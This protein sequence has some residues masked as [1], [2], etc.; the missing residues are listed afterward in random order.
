MDSSET[1]HPITHWLRNTNGF[2]FSLYVAFSAFCLY[3]CIFSLRKTFGV[4]TYDGIVVAGHSFKVWMVITQA[5]GYMLSKF[6]GIKIVSELG[7]HSRFKGILLMVSIAGLSWLGFALTPNPYN[8]IFLFFNG[9]PL[10][11]VWG[12]VFGYLEGRRSTEVLGASLSVSF[13]FSA[14]FAK[15]IGGFIMLHWGTSEFWMPFVSTCLFFPP[16]V[17]FLWMLNKIPPPTPEDEVLRTK[18]RPMSGPERIKLALTFAPGLILLI[19]AYTMLTA[20]RDFRDNFSAEI[21]KSLDYGDKPGIFT[22]TETIVTIVVL[23]V[24]GSLMVIKNNFKAMIINHFIVIIGMIT[25]GLSTMAFENKLIAAPTWMVLVGMGLYFGY[26]QFNSI[27]FDRIIATF[28]YVSTI[29]FLMYLADSFGYVGS[30]GVLLFKEFGNTELS[31][32]DFFMSS[33]YI[34][35]IA[36]SVLMS[37]SLVY[38]IWKFKGWKQG[39]VVIG[40]Q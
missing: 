18:R 40:K 37:G 30:I 32:L 1:N 7:A 8:L 25:V 12:M 21:W 23:I 6:I 15:T 19:L 5:I 22:F 11:M 20:Y 33:G 29:G 34:L 10:G 39:E 38:F 16:L 3:T 27:F 31:W 13:I 35:S 2:W 4:A 36:G 17:L 14:G 24:I 28:Q 26:I 9:L